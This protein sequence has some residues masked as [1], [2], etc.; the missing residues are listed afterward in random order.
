MSKNTVP[1]IPPPLA[2]ELFQPGPNVLYSL[3]A[4]AHLAGVPRRSILIYCRAGLVRPILQPPYEVMEFTEEA[5]HTIR[6]I[7][8]LRAVHGV[9][10]ACLKDMFDLLDEVERL[11][12]EVRFLRNR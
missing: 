12:A 2:L 8:Y 10:L 1:D 7:E 6:R 3:D 5:I 4:A 11:R 9:G